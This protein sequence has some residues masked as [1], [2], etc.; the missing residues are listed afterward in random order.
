M[1]CKPN[2]GFFIIYKIF[3]TPKKNI[4]N[5]GKIFSCHDYKKVENQMELIFNIYLSRSIGTFYAISV[6]VKHGEK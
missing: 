5:N 6:Y 3:T 1:I 4:G 2:N